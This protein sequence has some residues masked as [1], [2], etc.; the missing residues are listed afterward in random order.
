MKSNAFGL[1]ASSRSATV[2]R[3]TCCRVRWD[4]RKG[5]NNNRPHTNGTGAIVLP[6]ENVRRL[7]HCLLRTLNRRRT[8][9]RH[10]R[11]LN[12][13]LQFFHKALRLGTNAGDIFFARFPLTRSTENVLCFW[14]YLNKEY[15]ILGKT[16]FAPCEACQIKSCFW[17]PAIHGKSHSV[18]YFNK[19]PSV[20]I[21]RTARAKTFILIKWRKNARRERE[22][23]KLTLI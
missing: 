6:I 1:L 19:T 3:Q 12:F 17:S 16:N 22:L 13:F 9:R 20:C 11:S 7:G 5:Q 14:Y 4:R 10:S 2:T 8:A 21:V 15:N 18:E 23:L